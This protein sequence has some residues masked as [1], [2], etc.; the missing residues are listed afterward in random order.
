M[1]VPGS[2]ALRRYDLVG[3]CVTFLRGSVSLW[4]WYLRPSSQLFE[5][6]LLLSA[7]GS[8]CRTFGYSSPTSAWMLPGSHHDDNGLNL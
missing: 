2:G 8:R 5:N 1:F 6:S 3:A 4:G 7:F